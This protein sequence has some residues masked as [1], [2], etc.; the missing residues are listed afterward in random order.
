M[1]TDV[2]KELAVSIF[3]VEYGSSKLIEN[4]INLQGVTYQATVSCNSPQCGDQ[5]SK[6][7][8]PVGVL[9]V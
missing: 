1:G 4:V 9:L 5:L 8:H 6:H 2:S 3:R 7:E